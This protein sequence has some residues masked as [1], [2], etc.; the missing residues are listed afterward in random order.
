MVV[1]ALQLR[2]DL[3]RTAEE[4]RVGS[5]ILQIQGSSANE[6]A[7]VPKPQIN[8]QFTW[9]YDRMR[10]EINVFTSWS[11]QRTCKI[12]GGA[13]SSEAN[14]LSQ[15]LG[16]SIQR[17]FTRIVDR[18]ST[19]RA[20]EVL[21]AEQSRLIDIA[22]SAMGQAFAKNAC[23]KAITG[24]DVQ[25]E[26]EEKLQLALDIVVEAQCKN[27]DANALVADSLDLV[28]HDSSTYFLTNVLRFIADCA[29]GVASSNTTIAPSSQSTPTP[30]PSP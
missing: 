18:T 11:L 3:T 6:A 12:G 19:S 27:S 21:R 13:L 4:Q 25:V 9:V 22:A 14:Y 17:A 29:G 28:V 2:A 7:S 16:S 20:C 24:E 15:I 8:A 26:L 30:S 10:E 5:L 23:C 1:L